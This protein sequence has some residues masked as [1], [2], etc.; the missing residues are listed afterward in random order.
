[1]VIILKIIYVVINFI[2]Q[3]KYLIIH[4]SKC[5]GLIK[6]FKDINKISLNTFLYSKKK[7]KLFYI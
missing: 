5:N 4:E 6:G 3:K 2:K 7:F 1:V